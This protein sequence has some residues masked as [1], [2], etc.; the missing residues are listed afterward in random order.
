MRKVELKRAWSDAKVTLGILRVLGSDHAPIY[1]LENPL[2]ITNEDSRI[3][4]STYHCIPHNSAKYP[5]TYEVLGV[6]NRVGILLHWGNT[7][8][9]T[10][11]C[12]LLG[13]ESGNLQGEPAVL[14]SHAAFELF[15]NL[16]GQ[17]GFY[18][19]VRD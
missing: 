1:T 13:L 18:L 17:E 16:I 11:G 12:I 10:T 5:N 19:E 8:K 6:P 2:R 14:Q 7:E 15:R 9:D 4:A 3:P